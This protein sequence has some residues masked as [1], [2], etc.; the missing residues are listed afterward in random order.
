MPRYVDSSKIVKEHL[1]IESLTCLKKQISYLYTPFQTNRKIYKQR[2][3]ERE[4]ERAPEFFKTVNMYFDA[5]RVLKF[6]SCGETDWN[7]KPKIENPER[8]CICC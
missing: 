7:K 1:S 5:E 4:R 8:R 2:E 6:N 3:R